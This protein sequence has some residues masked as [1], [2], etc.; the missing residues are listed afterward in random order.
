MGNFGTGYYEEHFCE[1]ILT[2]DQ[3]FKDNSILA[4]VVIS[5]GEQFGTLVIKEMSIKDISS[6]SSG[7]HFVR[8]SKTVCAILVEGIMGDIHLKLF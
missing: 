2:L 7:S 6:F 3:S 5:G 8:W 4:L 1:T